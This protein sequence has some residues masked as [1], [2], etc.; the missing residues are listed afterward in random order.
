VGELSVHSMLQAGKTRT[1]TTSVTD[2]KYDLVGL[3][4]MSTGRKEGLIK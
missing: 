2:V 4:A 3:A 1:D